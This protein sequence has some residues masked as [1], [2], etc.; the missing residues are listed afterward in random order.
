MRV[1]LTYDQV[2]GAEH[3]DKSG[4]IERKHGNARVATLSKEYGEGFAEGRRK[5]VMLKTCLRKLAPHP[6]TTT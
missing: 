6:C 3:R 4:R 2:E 5:D 1:A